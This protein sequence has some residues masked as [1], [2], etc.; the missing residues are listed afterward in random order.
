MQ[1][2][3]GGTI[4]G[5]TLLGVMVRPRRISEAWVA[6]L[7]ALAMLLVGILPLNEIVPTLAREWNVYGFF[8]G[9]ML[10]AFFAEQAGVFQALALY[11]ARWANGSA[12]RLYVAVF[13][14]GTLITAVLSNDATALILTPVVWTLT[15]RLRLRALPFMFACTF[16]ADTASALLPVSNPINI[17]VLTRFNRELWEYWTYL[18]VPSLVCIGWNIGLFAWLFRCDLQGSYDLALLDDFTI[19][20]P[21]LYRATLI[22]LA[23]I[24][25]AYVGGSLWQV[26]LAFVALAGAALLAALSWWAGS[27]KPKHALHELSPALFGFISGMFLVVRAIEHLG[28]TE[29]FGASL[30]QGSSASLGNIARVIFGSALGS[31][32]INNV[33]M[34]LVMTSTLEHLPTQPAPALIYGTIFGADLG[35]NLTIVGSLATMLWLVILRRKGI[36]ISAKE[37]LKLGLIFVLPSLLIGTLWMWLMA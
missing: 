6:L 13:L 30:L 37:Y 27:F 26:P 3:L 36:E 24:A 9:L 12:Q 1:L 11:A 5:A 25:L 19:A 35:P 10:I 31:N 8:V 22:G 29:R 18:L 21:K 32:M 23:L 16:I 2:L 20:N 7:G 17:L 15:S 4:F 33:P 34:T 14:V 28:W